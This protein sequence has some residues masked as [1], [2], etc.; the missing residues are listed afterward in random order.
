MVLSKEGFY[1][2]DVP[3]TY[4]SGCVKQLALNITNTINVS[5]HAASNPDMFKENRPL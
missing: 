1:D 4:F 5:R 3:S 2:S